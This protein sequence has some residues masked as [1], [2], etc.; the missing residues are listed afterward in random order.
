M[1]ANRLK[2]EAH[3]T[4]VQFRAWSEEKKKNNTPPPHTHKV[5]KLAF[6]FLQIQGVRSILTKQCQ[7]RPAPSVKKTTLTWE[8]D[9]P[10]WPA[11]HTTG[12]LPSAPGCPFSP[13]LTPPVPQKMLSSL[14]L[15]STVPWPAWLTS[16]HLH[17]SLLFLDACT[18]WSHFPVECDFTFK[19]KKARGVLTVLR[20]LW[21]LPANDLHYFYSRYAF[22]NLYFGCFPTLFWRGGF[23]KAASYST[24]ALVNVPPSNQ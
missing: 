12:F 17:H 11:Q 10:S 6:L 22:P 9:H 13:I 21:K 3:M 8:R 18:S 1:A 20:L 5:V 14:H 16:G 19:K 15:Y 2:R 23:K 7:A 4:W 24:T